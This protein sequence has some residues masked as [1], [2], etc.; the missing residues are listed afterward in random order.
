MDIEL[1]KAK[2]EILHHTAH[3]AARGLY[4]GDSE[5]MNEL[6]ESGLMEFAGR[7][8]FVPDGYYRITDEGR[9]SLAAA[10]AGA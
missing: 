10:E 2:L 6:V 8:G 4:C 5:D 7:C 1:T 9:E 3:R